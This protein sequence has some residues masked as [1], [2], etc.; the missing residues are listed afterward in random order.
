MGYFWGDDV[1]DFVCEAWLDLG[2]A[3]LVVRCDTTKI[4]WVQRRYFFV[5]GAWLSVTSIVF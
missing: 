5:S 2:Q 4:C 1:L 3:L